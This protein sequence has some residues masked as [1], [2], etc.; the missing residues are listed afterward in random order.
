MSTKI[1]GY[2]IRNVRTGLFLKGGSDLSESRDGR[3]WTKK[4]FAIRSINLKIS[5]LKNRLRDRI[6]TLK[7]SKD[8]KE[9]RENTF[10]YEIVEL[11]EGNSIPMQFY[12][13]DIDL[14]S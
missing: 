3:T 4:A 12:I 7:M 11:V 2:K 14:V 13:G 6:T 9:F 10:N 8:L 1:L 5:L